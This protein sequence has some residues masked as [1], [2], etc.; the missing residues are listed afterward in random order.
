MEVNYY[1]LF[2]VNP[3]AT[4]REIRIAYRRMAEVYHP[5]KLRELP[6]KIREEGE[7]IM[8]LLNEAKSILMNP[9]R[10]LEYDVGRGYRSPEAEQAI[11]F[12]DLPRE[13]G[14]VIP[15]TSGEGANLT[16]K[17]SRVLSSLGD[18]FSRDKDFQQKIA[19]AQDMVEAKV[20]DDHEEPVEDAFFEVEEEDEI[21]MTVSFTVV[22]ETKRRFVKE[23]AGGREK[24]PFRIVAVETDEEDGEGDGGEE[25]DVEW[26]EE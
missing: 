19:I 11:V 2:G 13:M 14:Y 18:V 1:E 7:D 24:K 3:N 4:P 12:D 9:E 5:D 17:M 25:H 16:R 26:E 8:R 6:G 15:S 20:I 10:R 21:E 23:D 22:N